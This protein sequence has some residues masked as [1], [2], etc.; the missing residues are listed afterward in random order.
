M[1]DFADTQ[2]GGPTINPAQLHLDDSIDSLDSPFVENFEWMG[3]FNSHVV[4]GFG[5]QGVS[6]TSPCGPSNDSPMF[7][8]QPDNAHNQA[9][10]YPQPYNMIWQQHPQSMLTPETALMT[11]DIAAHMHSDYGLSTD[12]GMNNLPPQNTMDGYYPTPPPFTSLS[13][14]ISNNTFSPHFMQPMGFPTDHTAQPYAPTNTCVFDPSQFQQRPHAV[15]SITELTRQALL[16]S[17]S[18]ALSYGQRRYSQ[19]ATSSR[20]DSLSASPSLPS[21]EDLQR[22]VDAYIHFFQPHSPFL[23]IPTLSFDSPAY[24]NSIRVANG[25]ANGQGGIIGGGGCLILAMAAIGALYEL[26][27]LVSKDLFDAARKIIQLYLEE[28]RKADLAAATNSLRHNDN[29]GQNTPLWLVQAMLLTVIYGHQCGDKV[30]GDIA[31]THGAALVSLGRAAGLL[32]P[33]MEPN[34]QMSNGHLLNPLSSPDVER[35]RTHDSIAFNDPWGFAT[36]NVE[37]ETAW[38]N[39]VA[40]EER[41]RTLYAIFNMSSLLVSAYNHAPAIMN[42]QIHL[43]L[44][45]E[46]ELWTAESV[47]IWNARG[48]AQSNHVA[49]TF[50]SALSRLLMESQTQGYQQSEVSGSSML[51]ADLPPSDLKPSTF[52]CLVLINALHNFIWETR[53]R[54]SGARWTTQESEGMI[55]HMEAALRAWGAAW[56]GNPTH[57]P[58]RP[59]PFQMGPLSADSIPLLDLAYVRLYVNLGLS[60]EHAWARDF[61]QMAEEL[62][63]GSDIIQH[64]DYSRSQSSHSSENGGSRKT[65][66]IPGTDSYD[67]NMALS[68]HAEAE[69]QKT[70]RRER[71]L[72]KAAFYAADSLLFSSK[73][74]VT[75]MD[76]TARELPVQSAMC[77]FDCAQVL[78]EWI[79]TVQERIGGY[80]GMIGRD[81]IDFAQQLPPDMMLEDEDCKLLEKTGDILAAAEGKMTAELSNLDPASAMSVMNALPSCSQRGYGAQILGVTAFMLR[82]AAVWPGMLLLLF[83]VLRC[84]LLICVIVTTIMAHGLDIQ[85]AHMQKR[86]DHS[87]TMAQPHM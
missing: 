36:A 50:A 41:K 72:R 31:N 76:M 51:M 28:R 5:E 17:L 35:V 47:G 60:K 27:P 4:N 38:R 77:T 67:I 11:P 52:G 48:G 71:R 1:Y 16:Q 18:Q 46:E 29:T 56:N 58:E 26:E 33:A 87:I 64:A 32:S 74:G 19:S 13:P 63:R 86:A 37:D 79:T 53:Q 66:F 55:A 20:R 42:S 12:V 40:A 25:H 30:S 62:S 44:P 6:A 78:A 8:A 39:W 75:F 68:A 9:L 15:T 82:R 43:D 80:C 54:H 61:E 57:S 34:T 83:H 45:C 24:T 21:L 49:I 85:A 3:G 69:Q 22:Y 7:A 73:L 81:A 65:S 14:D 84:V 70:T 59:N 2:V 23:H 10:Y